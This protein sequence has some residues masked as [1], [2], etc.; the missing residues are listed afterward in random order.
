MPL[1]EVGVAKAIT[2]YIT[3]WEEEANE[4]DREAIRELRQA[5]EDLEREMATSQ[6][7]KASTMEEVD[8]STSEASRQRGITTNE[9]DQGNAIGRDDG[10]G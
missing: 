1:F 10:N 4:P 8:I 2:P 9:R 7:V 6:R 5:H 3:N